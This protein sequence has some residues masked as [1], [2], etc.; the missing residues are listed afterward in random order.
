MPQGRG[1]M[2]KAVLIVDD[3]RDL[4]NSLGRYLG[5]HGFSVYPAETGLE[6][7]Q[8]LLEGRIDIVV[9][10]VLLPDINGLDFLREMRRTSNVPVIML[11]GRGEEMDRIV[12]LEVGADDYVA[13]PFSPRELLARMGAVLRRA[14]LAGRGAEHAEPERVGRFADWSIDVARRRL[15]SP[16]GEDIKLSAGEFDVL[17]ILARNAQVPLTR[18]QILEQLGEDATQVFDRTIDTRVARL[19]RRIELDPK[20]PQFVKTERGSGYMFAEPVEWT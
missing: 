9:L 12:G 14:E 5:N 17:M 1:E 3:E 10:D 11:T 6:G 16:Q 20:N 8:I 4:L 19:R 18:E 2:T 7:R 13:K 15:I